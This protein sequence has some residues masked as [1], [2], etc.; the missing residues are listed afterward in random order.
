MCVCVLYK[1]GNFRGRCR[2]IEIQDKTD[3]ILI[4]KKP[5]PNKG[6]TEQRNLLKLINE[7]MW[8]KKDLKVK[9]MPVIWA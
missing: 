5:G 4:R 1:F 9:I 7:Y 8:K 6:L 3:N 2:R